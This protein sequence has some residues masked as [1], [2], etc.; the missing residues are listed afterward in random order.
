MFINIFLKIF[1][2]KV[3]KEE[4]QIKSGVGDRLIYFNLFPL[5]K[6]KQHKQKFL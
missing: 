3:Q 1:Q 5:G 6:I 4:K 2:I